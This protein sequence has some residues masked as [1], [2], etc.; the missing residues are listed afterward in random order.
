MMQATFDKMEEHRHGT[1]SLVAM[2]VG[3]VLFWP[4]GLAILFWRLGKWPGGKRECARGPR[5]SLRKSSGNSAFEAYKAETLERIEQERRRLA[6]EQKAFEQFAE[7]LQ[8]ARDREEFE[9]FQAARKQ[10]QETGV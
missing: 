3:F 9:Q 5:R 7:D 1:G 2:I 4:I 8:R 6:D 10:V